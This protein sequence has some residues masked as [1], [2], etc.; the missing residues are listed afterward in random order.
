LLAPPSPVLLRAAFRP[1][2]LGPTGNIVLNKPIV[3]IVG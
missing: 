3:G 1:P 2:F